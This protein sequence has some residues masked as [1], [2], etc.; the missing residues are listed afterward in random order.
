MQPSLNYL[1]FR[2]NLIITMK[3][4]YLF[5]LANCITNLTYAQTE[6]VRNVDGF[7][8]LSIGIPAD[9]TIT[10]G[11]KYKVVIKGDEDDLA[12]IE[13]ETDGK[14]LKIKHDDNYSFW[15]NKF[16]DKIKVFITMPN[17]TGISLAGSGRLI[18]KDKFSTD[19]FM[20]DVA[21]S[22]R[23]EVFI[24]ARE[25]D[26]NISGSGK[27]ILEGSS[28]EA[29][30][31]ITGSGDVEAGKFEVIESDISIAGSGNCTV[32]VSEK[33]VTRIVGSGDVYYKGNPKHVNN[34]SVGSGKIRKL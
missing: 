11:N 15:G 22:G 19:K 17:L 18:S 10:K 9:V 34:N 7:T 30:I 26:I 12:E 20:A 28:S 2:K 6:Q 8:A 4:L 13:T 32:K 21:G 25:T 24:N 3:Y 29:D 27:I 16:D 31:N 14:W 33:L 5:L 1:V 23:V